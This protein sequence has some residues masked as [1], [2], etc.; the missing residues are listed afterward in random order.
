MIYLYFSP[1]HDSNIHIELK[2][3]KLFFD[4]LNLCKMNVLQYNG[5][6]KH[7]LISPKKFMDIDFYNQL[8]TKDEVSFA[9]GDL[10]LVQ[11]YSEIKSQTEYVNR[12]LRKDLIIVPPL[13]TSKKGFENFQY[14]GVEEGVRYNRR[15][16]SWSAGLGKSYLMSSQI[17]Q[18]FGLGIID[19]ALIFAKNEGVV[20][21]KWKILKFSPLFKEE[22]ILVVNTSKDRRYFFTEEKHRDKKIVIC[23]YSTF[24]AI[25][26][27]EAKKQNRG[28][29]SRTRKTFFDLYK[30]GWGSE[31][32][33]GLFC[34]EIQELSNHS[35]KQTKAVD[36]IKD[37]CE[38]RYGY[39]GSPSDESPKSWYSQL[40]ILDST[41][42]P[43]SYADWWPTLFKKGRFLNGKFRPFMMGDLIPSAYE[44]F[45]KTTL[46]K[47]VNFKSKDILDLPP[48]YEHDIFVEMSKKH[49]DIVNEIVQATMIRIK[50]DNGGILDKN[51]FR[52]NIQVIHSALDNP[53]I[54][55]SDEKIA[56]YQFNSSLVKKLEKWSIKD[57]SK[58]DLF[59]DL[60]KENLDKG[61]KVIIYSSHP[62]TIDE[63]VDIYKDYKPLSIHG[64]MKP[65]KG[66]KKDEYK[67]HIAEKF[68]NDKKVNLGIFSYLTYKTSID[69]YEADMIIYF[70]FSGVYQDY[71]QSKSRVYRNGLK[72][73]VNC[74][75]MV[76]EKSLNVRNLRLIESKDSEKKS[77]F[78]LKDNFTEK[79]FKDI[80]TG[81]VI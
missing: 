43:E 41:L 8:K 15:Y 55:L 46:S 54:L 14:E 64:Q 26:E 10:D 11:S 72:K 17:S 34:D 18:L 59:N 61:K 51:A 29:S 80:L 79:D 37:F 6:L 35:S 5:E 9:V 70:D 22:D 52:A 16:F 63:L 13:T 49:G 30:L 65:P 71:D 38:F 81:E 28:F 67:F 78:S 23:S 58:F 12:R 56:K 19:K 57:N 21:T 73:E 50:E 44:Q 62:Q 69:L 39:S 60:V 1:E 31:G 7:F 33:I 45:K 36:L 27:E 76:I 2:H 20:S 3:S 24:R 48:F 74:Y 42:I 25:T 32:K 53:K 77:L 47:F 66:M 40:N 4:A 68:Q 75:R